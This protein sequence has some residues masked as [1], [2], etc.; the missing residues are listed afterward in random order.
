VI[1]SHVCPSSLWHSP[2]G[3]MESANH[4]GTLSRLAPSSDRTSTFVR[5]VVL[6]LLA[7]I[8]TVVSSTMNREVQNV[9]DAGS[10]HRTGR[11]NN[12]VL[13]LSEIRPCQSLEGY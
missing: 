10:T 1:Q 9:S 5:I 7:R 6:C 11:P 12:A 2:G 13:D 4:T 8:A 3:T